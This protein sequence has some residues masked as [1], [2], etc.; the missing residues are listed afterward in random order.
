MN[1]K[2]RLLFILLLFSHVSNA[3]LFPYNPR[4]WNTNWTTTEFSDSFDG[5][6]LATEKWDVVT[7]FGRGQCVFVDYPGVTYSVE[8]GYLHLNMVNAPLHCFTV[9]SITKCYNY[10]SAEITSKE[11]Y[12]YGIYEGRMK[13]AYARGSWPAFWFFGGS[14]ADDPQYNNGY[15]SEIDFAEYNWYVELF[16]Y[17]PKTE[18]VLHWWGPQGEL[19][20]EGK[21]KEE[22]SV[23]W[24]Y[25]HTFKLIYTPYYLKFYVDGTLNWNRS[26]FY[27]INGSGQQEEIDA[28]NIDEYTTYYEYE[29]FP[30]HEAKIALSQQV[31]G[32]VNFPITPQTSMFDWVTYKKF[33]LAPEITC[34]NLICS[35]GTATLDVD[36]EA[37]NITWQLS[38]SSLFSTTSGSGP[39]ANITA[40]SGAS[41]SGTITFSFEMPSGEEFT[42]GRTFW[43]G[44]PDDTKLDI[45][46]T[47]SGGLHE[48]M[49]CEITS[50][51]AQH[52]GSS[53]HAIDIDEYEWYMPYASDWDIYEEYGGGGIDMRYVEIDYWEDPPPST[54]VINI[55][56]HNT[57]GWSWWESITVGV[58]DNC[59]WFLMF[60]PT[61]ATGE[62]TLSIES[63]S[64]EKTFDETAEWD[65][66][67]YSETQLLK[68]KQTSLRGQSAKIQTAGWKEGVYLVRVNYNGEILTGKLVVKR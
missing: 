29:G 17:D 15:A 20:V 40:Q 16:G 65:L 53:G 8:N 58:D 38:P 14:G 64:A 31:V 4:E 18:H 21:T 23:N 67:I 57:C 60:S 12:K 22:A 33:F 36:S 11:L 48:I 26:K 55:R 19:P 25:W 2:N 24:N 44:I 9:D 52:D 37:T 34:P 32:N 51:E 45:R 66:E 43:V 30:M 50:A 7:N 41:G 42:A 63:A 27:I 39:T 56:A 6:L 61:P 5:T 62:T 13:F 46:T 28:E 3:Q 35:S 10:I 68:T 49:A 59:G 47:N 54:D 1:I